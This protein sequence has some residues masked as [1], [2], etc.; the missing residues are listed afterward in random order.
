MFAASLRHLCHIFAFLLC[1]IFAAS[2]PHLCRIFAASSPHLWL[3]LWL[4][5]LLLECFATS[6]VSSF[7]ALVAPGRTW[8]VATPGF[9]EL[10][11]APHVPIC[12]SS[13]TSICE[14]FTLVQKHNISNMPQLR[15]QGLSNMPL[16]QKR[17]I[18]QVCPTYSKTLHC[19]GD[20]GLV[21][22]TNPG[23]GAWKWCLCLGSGWSL[24]WR[25]GCGLGL[26]LAG[27]LPGLPRL[28]PA[29]ACLCKASWPLDIPILP[30]ESFGRVR[31]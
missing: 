3:H 5:L 28:V 14:H 2:L 18:T 15:K 21:A 31:F 6:R 10:H 27:H 7:T 22:S 11:K 24:V 17:W 19:D 13:K 20:L 29:L 12:P 23:V 4:H 9:T 26:G 8:L 16:L 25:L 30:H 1:R